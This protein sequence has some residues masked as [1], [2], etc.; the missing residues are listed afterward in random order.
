MKIKRQTK[1]LEMVKNNNVETQEELTA[2]LNNAGFNVTQATV[3]RDIREL[4]LTKVPISG[5]DGGGHKYAPVTGENPLNERILRMFGDGVLS[6]DYAQNLIIIKTLSGMAMA[7]AACLDVLNSH[8]MIGTEIMGTIAGDD[9]I[10]CA[11]KT[12]ECSIAAIGKMR[13][14]LE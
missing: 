10:F 11:V 4:R 6:I 13:E 12:E 8:D 9:C 14:L 7:V 3:S 2:L 5:R 1:I